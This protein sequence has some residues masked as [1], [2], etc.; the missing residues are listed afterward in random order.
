MTFGKMTSSH[1]QKRL[2]F[3]CPFQRGEFRVLLVNQLAQS[4]VQNIGFFH[5]CGRF[6]SFFVRLEDLKFDLKRENTKKK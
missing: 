4:G 3:F 1:Q 2:C 6:F 5:T